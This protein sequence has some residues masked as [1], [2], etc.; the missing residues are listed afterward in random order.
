[1]PY[2]TACSSPSLIHLLDVLHGDVVDVLQVDPVPVPLLHVQL[3]DGTSHKFFSAAILR[4]SEREIAER[5]TCV[6]LNAC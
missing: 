6:C 5:K 3:A 2:F 4:P 1:M